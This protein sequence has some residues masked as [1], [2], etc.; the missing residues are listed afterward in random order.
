QII[1]AAETVIF[2]K[3]IH[4][5]TMEDIAKQ[6]ELGKGT[7]YGYYKS[8]AEILLAIN[9]RALR[10]LGDLFAEVAA[11]ESGNGAQKVRSIGKAYIRFAYE[12]PEYYNFIS[13]FEAGNVAVDAEESAKNA[14][15]ANCE[16]VDAI[17]CGIE[18]GSIRSDINPETVSRCLWAMCTGVIQLVHVKGEVIAKRQNILAKEIFKQ[19]FDIVDQGLMTLE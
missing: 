2:N 18:D 9:E 10:K 19:F 12:Y 8:K 13:L 5:A 7:L 3:G 4:K 14:H 17:K 11:A 16:L 6:A 15:R 1:D